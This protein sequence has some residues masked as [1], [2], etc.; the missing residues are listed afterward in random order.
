MNDEQMTNNVSY[1]LVLKKMKQAIKFIKS[2][3]NIIFTDDINYFLG[4]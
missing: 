3:V 2:I 1:F 4:F